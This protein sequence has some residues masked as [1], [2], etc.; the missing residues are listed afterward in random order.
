MHSDAPLSPL[1][2]THFQF[3]GFKQGLICFLLSFLSF[4]SLLISFFYG[5]ISAG[6]ANE[7]CGPILGLIDAVNVLRGS[8]PDPIVVHDDFG[9]GN[10][11]IFIA[12]DHN[13]WKIKVPGFIF[14]LQLNDRINPMWMCSRVWR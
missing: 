2:V 12:I 11:A 7:P 3:L 9:I 6:A 13:I 5:L 1:V 10:A 8:S 14:L 4:L